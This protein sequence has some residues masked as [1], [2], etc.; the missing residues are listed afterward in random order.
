[1]RKI[2]ILDD[3]PSAAGLY[4]QVLSSAGHEVVVH[5]SFEEARAYLKLLVPDAL[6][7]DVRLGEYNG[8]QLAIVFRAL[9]PHA[10]ILIVSGHDD[11]VI[12]KEAASIG[13][14]FFV[15]PVSV[16]TITSKFAEV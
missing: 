9:S 13:A 3:D 1:M 5:T 15:K 4:A 6:L 7:A 16:D 2:L 12:R 10:V 8:L 11:P 14:E